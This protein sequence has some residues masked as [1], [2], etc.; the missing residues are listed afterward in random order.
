[1][2]DSALTTVDR[3]RFH[4]TIIALVMRLQCAMC[5]CFCFSYPAVYK[6]MRPE[7]VNRNYIFFTFFFKQVFKFAVITTNL[8]AH[9]YRVLSL[10]SIWKEPYLRLPISV[11]VFIIFI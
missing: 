1:M 9:N 4:K 5:Q 2:S 8:Y 10:R 3:V 11:L 7:N 6:K